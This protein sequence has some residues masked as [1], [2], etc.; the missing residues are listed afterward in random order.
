MAEQ[1][2]GAGWK[3]SSRGEAAWKE[4]RELVASRNAEAS[5]QGKERRETYERDR[6]EARRAAEAKLHVELLKQHG[7]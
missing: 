2:N 4:A 1:E 6:A 3:S 5:K 7:Q